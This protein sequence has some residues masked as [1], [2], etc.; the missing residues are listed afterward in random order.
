MDRTFVL[1]ENAPAPIAV[2]LLEPRLD[3]IVTLDSLPVYSVRTPP[4][5]L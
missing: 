4:E 1:P 5:A 2:T 3:G